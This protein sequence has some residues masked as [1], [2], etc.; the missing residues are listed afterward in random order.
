[1]DNAA[2]QNIVNSI[3][4][5]LANLGMTQL[6][7][8]EFA[9][10]GGRCNS[11]AIDNSAGVD[12]SDHEV[13]IKILVDAIVADGEM[14]SKQRDRLLAKMTD[15]VASHV[16]IDNYLQTQAVTVAQSQAAARL[17]LQARFMRDL[18]RAGQLDRVIEFLPDDEQ[19]TELIAAEQ[20]LA[21]PELS[22]LIAYAKMAL[23]DSLFA[24]DV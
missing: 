9:R 19:I 11:D 13:N 7:R 1:M 12:C 23:Y 3:Q 24:R 22:V 16:L 4:R 5:L 21:R 6:G 10:N 8:I 14:T 15:D 20:G 2:K 17:P 18:E